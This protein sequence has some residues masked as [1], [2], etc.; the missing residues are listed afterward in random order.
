M[1]TN[2]YNNSE[3][4]DGGS[5]YTEIGQA[6]KV[7]WYRSSF[8]KLLVGIVAIA[9]LMSLVVVSSDRV[10]NYVKSDIR[11]S[12]K[13][14]DADIGYRVKAL[15]EHLVPLAK[16][17]PKRK[18]VESQLRK[19][20][21]RA[22]QAMFSLENSESS[23]LNSSV[24][25]VAQALSRTVF[26]WHNS[27]RPMIVQ[28]L[29]GTNTSLLKPASD[30]L[31]QAINDYSNLLMESERLL[32]QRVTKRVDKVKYLT[33]VVGI[34][35]LGL[36]W[37]M[38]KTIQDVAKRCRELTDIANR[39]T[40]GQLDVYVPISGADELA[41]LGS[42]FNVMISKLSSA[43]ASERRNSAFF[44]RLVAT[45]RET[46]EHLAGMAV[47]IRRNAA[48]QTQG[49]KGQAVEI[50][51]T[52]KSAA[53]IQNEADE[54]RKTANDVVQSSGRAKE[55]SEAGRRAIDDTIEGIGYVK[56][57]SEAILD[58]IRSLNDDCKA[59]EDIV[60]VVN[61]IADKTNMLSLNASIE[62]SR[63]GEHGKGFNVVATEIRSLA[64]HSKS[65][66]SQVRRVLDKISRRSQDALHLTEQGQDIVDK[67]LA[68]VEQAGETIRD[69]EGIV[70]EYVRLSSSVAKTTRGAEIGIKEIL[71]AVS[72]LND[73]SDD[74][75]LV[76]S[77]SEKIA[78]ELISIGNKLKHQT[79]ISP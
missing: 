56:S 60:T 27:L 42:A 7:T 61:D 54:A 64:E 74:N 72:R 29:Y 11:T 30:V 21:S 35:V 65:T 62:A 41:H 16:E 36:V 31:H 52:M 5:L 44:Q 33:I 23:R 13:I 71:E 25:E 6:D 78:V 15:L 20:I 32:S 43:I 50:A 9:L 53:D 68:L 70:S 63:A 75:L 28:M 76:T 66:T 48:K 34:L 58:S 40:D 22:D 45:I 12:S 46:T 47:E 8:L 4:D 59:I 67:T 69:L 26:F 57:T 3:G 49:V 2:T 18:E 24:P 14:Q 10:L 55:V 51:R 79:V 37:L 17:E 73:A 1:N 39:I 77:Q 38:Y 19:L